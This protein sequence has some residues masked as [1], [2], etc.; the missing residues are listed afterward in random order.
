[1]LPFS[2]LHSVN[3]QDDWRILTCNARST[4]PV[5]AWWNGRKPRKV[6]KWISDIPAE[7]RTKYLVNISLKQFRYNSLPRVSVFEEIHG[8]IC[9]LSWTLWPIRRAQKVK[10]VIYI[11][12]ESVSNLDLDT[13]ILEE[14]FSWFLSVPSLKF[15]YSATTTPSTCVPFIIH[16]TLPRCSVN[17]VVK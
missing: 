9:T 17:S 13:D 5:F 11:P 8:T 4:N 12:D 15:C 14:W 7:V 1:M 3:K 16:H 10:S 2:T 6:S